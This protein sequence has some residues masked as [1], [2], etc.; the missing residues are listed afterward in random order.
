MTTVHGNEG[1]VNVGTNTVAKVTAFDLTIEA[2]IADAT[3]LGEAWETHQGGAPK[4]WSGTITCRRF[5]D[6]AGQG[7]L[8]PG[9]SVTLNL[10]GDGNSSGEDY[11]TGTASVTSV[12]RTQNISDA[13][14]E[15]FEFAGNGALTTSTVV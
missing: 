13:V 9:A 6:D 8:T 2:P 15:T 3:A 10:Y 12:G 14:E 4:R 11:Y 1:S 7:A 5:R